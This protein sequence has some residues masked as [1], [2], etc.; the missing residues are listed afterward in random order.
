MINAIIILLL[1][2]STVIQV[3][4]MC[5]FLP[6]WIR[7]KFR[8]N[9]SLDTLEVLKELGINTNMYKRKN[10]I[11]GI[12]RDY[13]KKNIEKDIKKEL[14]K[15]IIDKKVSVGRIRK[16]ELNY[17][18]DLIG[19]SCNEECAQAYARVLTS[20]WSDIV[21]KSQNV[22]NPIID[23]VVTP[24]GG[25]PILGYEFSKLIN[26]PFVLH[27]ENA[28]FDSEKDDMRRWFD[29]AVVPPKGAKALIVD[30]STTGGRMV[31][32]VVTNLRKYGYDVSECLVVFEPQNKDARKKLS[33]LE[34]NL[35]SIVKTHMN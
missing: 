7:K 16:T 6:E 19:H 35:I 27:E 33:D 22:K 9:K 17:Y 20:Y 31:L 2:I 30:D 12:P 4:D 11:V 8:I 34:I 25:S 10:A 14:K 32:N 29:C 13:N 23:F 15:L 5:G 24:K 3:C 21:E 1:G 18:I 26:K 28:R